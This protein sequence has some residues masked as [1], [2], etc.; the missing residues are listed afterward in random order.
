M[1]RFS[2]EDYLCLMTDCLTIND[3]DQVADLLK[4]LHAIVHVQTP[5]AGFI[6][7][8]SIVSSLYSL[9]GTNHQQVM[10]LCLQ[11]ILKVYR[12]NL[13][14]DPPLADQLPS[15]IDRLSCLDVSVALFQSISEEPEYLPVACWLVVDGRVDECVAATGF[16]NLKP[17]NSLWPTSMSFFWPIV[18]GFRC[19]SAQL[20]Q[21]ILILLASC[22]PFQWGA[23][24]LIVRMV[25]HVLECDAN[26]LIFPLM[27]LCC[28]F[29]LN[30]DISPIDSQ[31]FLGVTRFLMFC[32]KMLK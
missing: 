13:L 23:V 16:A 12:N 18:L 7:E 24:I 27:E 9:L 21:K 22:E 2:L 5:I 8:I 30:T 19:Q 11:I 31:V 3:H 1:E 29:I 26:N 15:I 20:R 14:T 28:D 10:I 6:S 25:S 4:I 17:T 32:R